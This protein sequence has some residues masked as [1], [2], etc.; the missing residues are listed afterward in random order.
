[1]SRYEGEITFISQEQGWGYVSI[2]IDSRVLQ[3]EFEKKHVSG[4]IS[5]EKLRNM[6]KV[7][8]FIKIP[9]DINKSVQIEKIEFIEQPP[10]SI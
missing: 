5:F 6:N 3:I 4:S 9:L 1:M 8:V 7:R 10:K 2:T